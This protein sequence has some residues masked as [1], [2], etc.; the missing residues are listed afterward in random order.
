VRGRGGAAGLALALALAGGCR[1]EGF[2]PYTERPG[3]YDALSPV[4]VQVLAEGWRLRAAGDLELARRRLDTLAAAQPGNLVAATALQDVELDLL[5]AG[6]PV[7]GVPP[8]GAAAT[9]V[10]RLFPVY[11]ARAEAEG[12][13]AACVLAAR[14]EPNVA[15]REAW[16]A[17]ALAEDPDCVWAHYALASTYAESKE[18]ARAWESLERALA[19]DP[20]HPLSR[21][22]E[23]ALLARGGDPARAL[24]A[25]RV[26]LEH[27]GDDPRL[28]PE[29]VAGARLDLAS[30]LVN[31]NEPEEALA[32]L[33]PL[34]ADLLPDPADVGLARATALDQLG[35]FDEAL[36][37]A[38]RLAEAAP[39]DARPRVQEAVLLG[40]RFHDAAGARAAWEDVL[41]RLDAEAQQADGGS[42]AGDPAA[43][44]L[45]SL[46]LRLR[47]R[48]E[49]ARLDGEA[50][51]AEP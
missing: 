39:L 30:L 48:A 16:L 20:G 18:H 5:T 41:V 19:L 1:A 50:P 42:P 33:A 13:A 35:R 46:F 26:W 34:D 37:E 49:L 3:P 6:E 10:A 17:R 36:A 4:E 40:D 29:I 21:R 43:Q 2:D 15:A 47:A 38:R 44:E 7:P 8:E 12:T 27:N 45:T 11:A 31:A 24:G 28:A 23:A 32:A 22:L 9:P 25:Y 51:A 14:L